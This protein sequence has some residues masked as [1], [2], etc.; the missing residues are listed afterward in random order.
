VLG[1]IWTFAAASFVLVTFAAAL[2]AARES[3]RK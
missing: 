1:A 3:R 2:Q